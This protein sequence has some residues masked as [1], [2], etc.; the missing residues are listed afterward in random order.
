MALIVCPLC[1][2]EDDVHLVQTLPDGRKEARCDD[3][4]FAFV[5]GSPRE[6]PKPPP[7]KTS[8]PRA[9]VTTPKASS[10]PIQV[11]RKQFSAATSISGA[12]IE[13]MT[14]LKDEFLS[15]V[16]YV[17]DPN[18]ESHQKKYQWVFS[19][20]GLEKAA[21]YD[22]LQFAHDTTGGDQGST[23]V[24]D[25]AWTLMGEFEGARRV[26][27]VVQHL[28]RGDGPVEDRFTSVADGSY[29]MSMP[30]FDEPLVTKVL[31]VA[32]PYRFLPVLTYDAKR[33]IA[34]RVL[35]VE[36]PAPGTAAWTIGRLAVWSNEL[37]LEALG[38]GFDDL[39]QV[40]QFLDWAQRR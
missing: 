26:R 14:T 40:A 2:R 23:E 36:L 35:G 8:T 12:A 16:E 22:L 1:V 34:E 7:R 5:Y 15:T 13:H 33:Q 32:E 11:A 18:V 6:E 4:N 27:A 38:N 3:C 37:I 30:G 29:A 9:R 39:H 28:L 19:A 24:F 20:D 31:A 25:K 21:I 10:V 17:P